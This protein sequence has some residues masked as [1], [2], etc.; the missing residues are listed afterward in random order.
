MDLINLYGFV[1]SNVKLCSLGSCR[2]IKPRSTLANSLA[3]QEGAGLTSC[4]YIEEKDFVSTLGLSL[5]SFC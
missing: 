3:L 4:A 5:L 1:V 2:K